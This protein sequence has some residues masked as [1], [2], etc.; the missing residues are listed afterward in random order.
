MAA[1]DALIQE[2]RESCERL[3]SNESFI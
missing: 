1:N 3:C 2:M